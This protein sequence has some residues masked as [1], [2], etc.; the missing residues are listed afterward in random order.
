[1]R[2]AGWKI[3][4]AP[5]AWLLH[6]LGRITFHRFFGRKVM[7]TNHSPE[8]RYYI[9]RNRLALIWRYRA[10]D[11]EWAF[12]E[13]KGGIVDTIKVLLFEEQ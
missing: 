13:F 1:M 8:R 2:A 9:H 12:G 6:S 7:T 5:D 4:E 3:V 11:I 10:K